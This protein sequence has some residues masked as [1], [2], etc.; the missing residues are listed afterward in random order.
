MDPGGNNN[1]GNQETVDGPDRRIQDPDMGPASRHKS[2]SSDT[3][4]A[5]RNRREIHARSSKRILTARKQLSRA[6]SISAQSTE[7]RT[8]SSLDS[9]VLSPLSNRARQCTL[10]V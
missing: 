6:S 4:E 10:L 3:C 5:R 7:T 2:G 9:R 8:S 1:G